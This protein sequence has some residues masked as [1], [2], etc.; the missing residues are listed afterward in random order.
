MSNVEPSDLIAIGYWQSE[1]Q[2]DLPQ[3]PRFVGAPLSEEV[4]EKLCSYLDSGV[5]FMACLGYSYC[6]FQCGVPDHAMGCRDLTDGTWIWPE[7]LSHY[8]RVHGLVLPSTFI[9]HASR[10]AWQIR[11]VAL[12]QGR[13]Y[14][15]GS[16]RLPVTYDFWK[17]Y[18]G[19]EG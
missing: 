3:P 10:S 18:A 2:P 4:R 1:E 17:G 13:E 14:S 12:P 6:R 11:H 19:T 9:E 15:D 8:V 7:G 16:L 5:E